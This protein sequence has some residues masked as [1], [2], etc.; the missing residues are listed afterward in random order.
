LVYSVEDSGGI[1]FIP[2]FTGLFGNKFTNLAP[3][4]DVNA[5]G[6][7]LGLTLYSKK[8]HIVR[9]LLQGIWLIF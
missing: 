8:A 3:Y 5:R 1:Y 7:I 6:T 2:A 9:A 4:W